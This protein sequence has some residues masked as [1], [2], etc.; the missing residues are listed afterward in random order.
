MH[1]FCLQGRLCAAVAVNRG[2]CS[3]V[4]PDSNPTPTHAPTHPM[5]RRRRSMPLMDLNDPPGG[6]RRRI[7]AQMDWSAGPLTGLAS[8]SRNSAPVGLKSGPFGTYKISLEPH[9]C[10]LYERP[11]QFPVR[12]RSRPVLVDVANTGQPLSATRSNP[13][14]FGRSRRLSGRT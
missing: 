3:G 2:L 11:T 1:L 13:D 8:P 4:A 9:D 10:R 12:R 7:R 5:A 14:R 6:F